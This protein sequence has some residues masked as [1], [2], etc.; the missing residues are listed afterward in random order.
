MKFD[1]VISNPPYMRYGWLD[2]VRK[3]LYLLDEG[4]YYILV[5]PSDTST[6][7]I[8]D[9][10]NRFDTVKAKRVEHLTPFDDSVVSYYIWKK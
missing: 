6:Q 4:S 8:K 10:C 1:V 5:C 2:H 3:H 9:I 7:K